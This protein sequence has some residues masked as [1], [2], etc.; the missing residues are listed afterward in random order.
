M[1]VINILIRCLLSARRC[2]LTAWW[3]DWLTDSR[4]DQMAASQSFFRAFDLRERLR[5]PLCNIW[6]PTTTVGCSWKWEKVRP[7]PNC[8]DGSNQKMMRASDWEKFSAAAAVKLLRSCN[9]RIKCDHHHHL[10]W[11]TYFGCRSEVRSFFRVGESES[12]RWRSSEE[13]RIN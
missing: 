9:N 13:S 12:P 3:D 1:S 8:Y 6:A 11:L 5:P 10:H 2:W 4:L 7:E